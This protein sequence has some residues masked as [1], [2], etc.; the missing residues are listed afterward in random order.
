MF[1]NLDRERERERAG[2][3]GAERGDRESQAGSALSV[4][5]LMQGSIP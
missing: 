2:V 5:T 1:I 3:G 4:Q